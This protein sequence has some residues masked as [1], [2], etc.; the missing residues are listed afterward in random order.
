MS[1]SIEIVTG[2]PTAILPASASAKPTLT[3]M[4]SRSSK[5]AKEFDEPLDPE[6][7][8]APEPELELELELEALLP[9]PP[10]VW[11]TA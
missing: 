5:V 6:P 10:T 1:E 8:P 11:P 3:T 2:W 4:W 7:L 9:P